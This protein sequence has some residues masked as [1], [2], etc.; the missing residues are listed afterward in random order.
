[1]PG[2]LHKL[3]V[4]SCPAC[5]TENSHPNAHML[6]P[7]EFSVISNLSFKQLNSHLRTSLIHFDHVSRCSTHDVFVNNQKAHLLEFE[8]E[9][10]IQLQ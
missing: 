3:H 4:V 6:L 10:T 9:S 5:S 7:K 1:M 2:S 8:L